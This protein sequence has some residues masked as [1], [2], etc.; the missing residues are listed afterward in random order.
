MGIDGRIAIYGV[1]FKTNSVEL[2]EGSERTIET[3][4]SLLE[5]NPKVKIAVVGYTDDK[6]EYDYNY[7]LGLSKDRADAVVADLNTAHGIADDR[8]FAAGASFLSPIA[9]ND[10]EQGRAL[11]RFSDR[12]HAPGKKTSAS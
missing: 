8:L 2:S 6:G 3:I 5:A 7:N 9:S 4:A 12:G 10:S 11:I 1:R